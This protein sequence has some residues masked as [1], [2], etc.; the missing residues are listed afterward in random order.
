VAALEA[1]PRR[2]ALALYD[3]IL[4]ERPDCFW[5]D[6]R[7]A[8]VAAR[9]GEYTTA[10]HN[11]AHCVARRPRN[12]ALRA[13]YAGCLGL[14]GRLEP[15]L[16]ECDQAEALDPELAETYRNR[17]LIRAR[18]GGDRAGIERDIEQFARLTRSRG[19]FPA[20]LLRFDVMLSDATRR[21]TPREQTDLM[22]EILDRDPERHEVRTRLA[23]ELFIEGRIDEALA[24]LEKV[25]A[26]QPG[27]LPAR[28]SRAEILRTI[29]RVEEAG[30][31]SS[32]IL[33][34][35]R[36][37]E[38]FSRNP[39]AIRAYHMAALGR[40][41]AKRWE[42]G[43]ALARTGVARSARIKSEELRGESY[44][45]LAV[46]LAGASRADPSLESQAVSNL[47]EAIRLNPAC[48]AW[49]EKER[50]VGD[51]ARIERLISDAVGS[52]S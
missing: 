43:L 11:L 51:P 40:A 4:A 47:R 13:Q 21:Y 6:Y 31:I 8:A 29:G 46:V 5:A 34:D 22:V 37:Q 44:Y 49:F 2:E 19:R 33:A 10:A 25:H 28:L 1:E 14:A 41:H 24:Q 52:G 12:A 39:G 18:L 26:M 17:A 45:A 16:A 32:E 48:R 36:F 7:A 15:A 3:A 50:R 20:L 42:D 35:E 30:S 23:Y 9:L 38:F 27:Y